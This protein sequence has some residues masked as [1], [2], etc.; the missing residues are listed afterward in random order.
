M[1]KLLISKNLII[2]YGNL[3]H[4]RFIPKS[5]FFPIFVITQLT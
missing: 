4:A 3:C 2:Y 1:T 5:L